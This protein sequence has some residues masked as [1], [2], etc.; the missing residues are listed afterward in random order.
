VVAR[1]RAPDVYACGYCHTPTGQGRPE[2]A[3]LA[4]LP[5]PYIVQQLDDFKSGVRRS[6]WPGLYP[7]TDLMIHAAT[8]ATVDEVALAAQYF[9]Q[10]KLK[11]H[12]LVFERRRV[13]R[14]GVV[15]LVYSAIPGAPDEPLGAR[16]LP[17]YYRRKRSDGGVR[18]MSRGR[19]AGRRIGALVADQLPSR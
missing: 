17:S 8:Y 3:S 15:G 11:S 4:G 16:Q 7:P 14:P 9:S 10:Q 1:G 18:N 12:V 2:N 19:P 13:P 6:A 5:V